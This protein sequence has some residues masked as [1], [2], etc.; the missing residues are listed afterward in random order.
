MLF[1]WGLCQ[2][3][4]P[5]FLWVPFQCHL[6]WL[7]MFRWVLSRCRLRLFLWVL[8]QCHLLWLRLFRWD[9][10]QCRLQW[11]RRKGTYTVHP[12]FYTVYGNSRRLFL[13]PPG[14]T[15]IMR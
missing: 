5:L 3:R 1:L 15:V 13:L 11:C 9:P 4:L 14:A 6:L 8:F 2:C 7:R 10:C 12:S